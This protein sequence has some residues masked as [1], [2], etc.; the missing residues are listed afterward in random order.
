VIDHFVRAPAWEWWILL[1]FFCAG[2]AG[3][4][5]ALG[6][7]LRFWG[8]PRDEGITRAAFI[9]SF[10]ALIFCPIFLTVDL[11]QPIRFWHML[12]DTGAGGLVFKFW[13][14]MSIGSWALLLFGL[15]SF[16]SF[17]VALASGG[18]LRAADPLARWLRGRAG[19][20]WTAIGMILGLFIAGYTGVLLSVSNQPVWSDTWMLGGLFLA[21]GLS[22]AAAVLILLARRGRGDTDTAVALSDADRWFVII[23]AVLIVLFVVTVAAAGWLASLLGPVLLLLWLLVIVGIAAPIVSHSRRMTFEPRVA[24]ALTL[25]GVLALRAVVIFSA[26]L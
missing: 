2:I 6:A 26:Q 15:F 14:P 21:S 20:V 8:S 9:T 7:M 11:G 12:F 17:L 18:Q 16:V 23:E 25:L 4:A 5:Y 1:Y 24:A 13:S 3:G 22:G 19:D 10:I